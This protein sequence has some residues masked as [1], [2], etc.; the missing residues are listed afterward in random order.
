MTFFNLSIIK[1][2][3]NSVSNCAKPLQPVD[4]CN[5]KCKPKPDCGG[6][7]KTIMFGLGKVHQAG[8]LFGGGV[9]IGLGVGVGVGAKLI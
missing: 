7:S 8:I 6:H 1:S 4:N 5:D 9:G 2:S 3:V